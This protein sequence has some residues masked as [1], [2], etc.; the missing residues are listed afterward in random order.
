MKLQKRK[1]IAACKKVK[2]NKASAYDM[3][4]NEM[5][6]SALPFIKHTVVKVFNKLLQEG[7]FPV[8]WTE[9]S[10]FQFINK[11]VTQ[12]RIIIGE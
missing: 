10:L 12:I 4:K 7:Q 9:T 3:V 11:G 1:I 8:S 2:N 5:I 6:K